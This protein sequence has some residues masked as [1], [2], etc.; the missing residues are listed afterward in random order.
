MD[1]SKAL[2]VHDLPSHDEAEPKI[3]EYAKELRA[4]DERASNL[5]QKLLQEQKEAE[6][7]KMQ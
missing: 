7:V 3:I 6:E 5:S 1:I 4:S 2:H